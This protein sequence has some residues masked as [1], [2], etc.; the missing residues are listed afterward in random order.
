MEIIVESNEKDMLALIDDSTSSARSYDDFESSYG[1]LGTPIIGHSNCVVGQQ[2][3]SCLKVKTQID[4]LANT[5]PSTEPP[6][7]PERTPESKLVKFDSVEIREYARLLSDHPATS[8]GA[9]IGIGWNHDPK[10]TITVDLSLYE[11]SREGIRR[12]KKQ[13][14][15]PRDVRESMLREIGYSGKQI[16]EAARMVRKYK[17]R[18]AVTF[19]QQKFDGFLE[20]VETVKDVV[21]PFNCRRRSSLDN[22]PYQ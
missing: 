18:R 17:E 19:H 12:T 16:I 11:R 13:L 8:S 1:C 5:A 14:V 10:A 22:F 20:R 2:I 21:K 4:A 9:P 3:K 15:I 7:N 6:E